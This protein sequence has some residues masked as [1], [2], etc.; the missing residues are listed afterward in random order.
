M[1]IIN[2]TCVL[3]ICLLA[4]T[5]ILLYV[6]LISHD[7]SLQ[8][9]NKVLKDKPPVYLISYADGADIF[10][11]NQNALAHSAIN[12]GID[13]I[14]NYNKQHIDPKF[15]TDNSDIFTQTKGAGLWLWKPW[16]I[17]KTLDLI[18]ED[19][20]LIYAD[21]SVIFRR[22]I[23]ELIELSNKKNIIL[24]EHPSYTREQE[25]APFIFEKLN[26]NEESCKTGPA[27]VANFIML[28]NNSSTRLFIQ[29]WLN[30]C[31]DRSIFLAELDKNSRPTNYI[32][33]A[34]DQAILSV[35]T[36]KFKDNIALLEYNFA[37][38]TYIAAAYRKPS[39]KEKYTQNHLI[40]ANTI[41]S[42]IESWFANS[43]VTLAIRSM[44]YKV[45]PEFPWHSEHSQSSDLEDH[46]VFL[47]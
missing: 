7:L 42:P 37:C 29:E 18:P 10:Y 14:Y 23:T 38:D 16:L 5:C 31:L 22:P 2:I 9:K 1:R 46:L 41:M 39:H 8:P 13:F 43:K 40:Y 25:V 35:M 15:I 33:H 30:S 11:K 4:T 28:R 44:I 3:I 6:T 20:L 36:H 45:Q 26:C 12:K 27:T 47:D 24:I 21:T 32:R 17:N 34:H 19:A